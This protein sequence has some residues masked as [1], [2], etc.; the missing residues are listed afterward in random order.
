MRCTQ[1]RADPALRQSLTRSPTWILFANPGFYEKILT[2]GGLD[3]REQV[4]LFF[5]TRT[6]AIGK[7]T[8]FSVGTQHLYTLAGDQSGFSSKLWLCTGLQHAQ[9]KYGDWLL[10]NVVG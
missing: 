10:A 7:Q 8:G 3:S 1:R 6:R 9:F 4:S 5:H 2:D